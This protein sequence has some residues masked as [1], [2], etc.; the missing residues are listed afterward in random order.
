[1]HPITSELKQTI[2]TLES[3][4]ERF[5]VLK[6]K[7]QGET[8]YLITCGP[9]LGK[10]NLELLNEKLKD[11]LVIS[12]KQ[13]YDVVSEIADYHL[14]NTYN[15][16]EYEYKTDNTIVMWS[17]SK[18]Y[19][20]NQLRKIGNKPV[21]FY[22][23]VNQ[24]IPFTSYSIAGL[25]NYDEMKLLG[26]RCEVLWGPG[27]F[28]E[29]MMPLCLQLGVKDIV[30]IGWDLALK[31]SGVKHEHF[32]EEEGDC[33]PQMGELQQAIISTSSFYLK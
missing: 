6:D 2:S 22:F 10:Q 3:I 17:I 29:M 8:A 30:I 7:Y 21:D 9:S 1:M 16:K 13:A 26:T 33:K 18:T 11:K 4:E 15:L 32:Y 5:Q 25:Q 19:A 24:V 27:M 20:E 23:P 14:L 12:V 31:H 28:Y